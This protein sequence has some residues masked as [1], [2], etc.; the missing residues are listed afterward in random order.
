MQ[1]RK[2][3][4]GMT[5]IELVIS[6]AIMA[7]VFSMIALLINTATQSFKRT[8]QKVNLQ[9]EAQVSMNQI[10][11]LVMETT[12][13]ESDSPEG[14]TRYLLQTASNEY[15]AVYFA[16][17]VKKIFLIQSD[18]IDGVNGAKTINP[19][20]SKETQNQYLLAEYVESIDITVSADKKT[21][22]IKIVFKIEKE[23]YTASKKVTL[24]NSIKD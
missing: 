21:V 13:Y 3:N 12:M 19:M 5:L 23:E 11:N 9:L 24:R 2:N 18:N 17:A 4:K 7:I 22:V 20:A 6:M 10:S 16:K 14:N 15:Y 8:N 1:L